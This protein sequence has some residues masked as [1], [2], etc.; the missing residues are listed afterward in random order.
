MHSSLAISITDESRIAQARRC[1]V[2]MAEELEFGV[3]DAGRVA[4]V[5]TEAAT[6]LSKHAQKGELMMGFAGNGVEIMAL[7]RGPGI[8]NVDQ[9]MGDGYSTAG[10]PGTGLGAIRRVSSSFDIHSIPGRGTVLVS[11]IR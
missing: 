4:L 2:A 11:H 10:S 3:P 9:C 1:A 6:N 8:A 5:A 7:D